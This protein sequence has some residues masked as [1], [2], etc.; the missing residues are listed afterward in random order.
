LA[1]SQQALTQALGPL[2]DGW[3]QAVTPEGEL[4]FIDH[5]TRKTSWFDPRLRNSIFIYFL[6][7]PHI[8]GSLFFTPSSAIHMQKPPMVHAAGTQSAAALQQ[9]QQI[10]QQPAASGEAF[11]K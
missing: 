3:E 11:F 7:V 8:N 2:P 4:Y 5:H 1:A 6:I 10:T 9:Q